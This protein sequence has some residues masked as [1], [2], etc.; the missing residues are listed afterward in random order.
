MCRSSCSTRGWS[1]ATP[2]SRCCRRSTIPRA[3][4]RQ[5]NDPMQTS[6]GY[7][8][9]ATRAALRLVP[10]PVLNHFESGSTGSLRAR[11]SIGFVLSG[12][13]GRAASVWD[14]FL[15]AS[16]LDAPLVPYNAHKSHGHID[17]E[18]FVTNLTWHPAAMPVL[19]T[20]DS[21]ITLL[22]LAPSQWH[23]RPEDL[24]PPNAF[25]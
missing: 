3:D 18:Q 7:Q 19:I 16:K 20:E 6:A 24:K 13:L 15:V 5:G 12:A 14:A 8:R 10:L 17:I 9:A 11:L 23:R 21:A 2:R 4:N 22:Q 25:R 1:P